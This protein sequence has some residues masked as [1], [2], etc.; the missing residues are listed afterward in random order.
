MLNASSLIAVAIACGASHEMLHMLWWQNQS[1][2]M[3]TTSATDFFARHISAFHLCSIAQQLLH[4][5][6]QLGKILPDGSKAAFMTGGLATGSGT[7]CAR[8]PLKRSR[9]IVSVT[10]PMVKLPTYISR[11]FL[12]DND[13]LPPV[14]ACNKLQMSDVMYRSRVADSP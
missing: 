14:R 4:E 9:S 12:L 8:A 11:C 2:T 1:H 6:Q 7:R 3:Q 13:K 5:E 10:T